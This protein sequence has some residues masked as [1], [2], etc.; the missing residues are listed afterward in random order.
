MPRAKRPDRYAA[1]RAAMLSQ[2]LQARGVTDTA[3]LAALGGLPR[4][5]FV[6]AG[7]EERAYD[8]RALEIGHGQT[9]SQPYM[10]ARMSEELR[11]DAWS[12]AHP[13]SVPK[14]LDVGG[15]SGYQ[16]AV[17]AR[18]GAR[19]ISVE[20]DPDLA[21]AAARRLA[22]LR[23]GSVEMVIGDGSGGWPEAAPYAGI[24]VGA[25]APEVP[26]PLVEQLEDGGR[27]VIPVGSR[28]AQVLLVV[29][30][31]GGGTNERPLE[32]CVFVPLL[33]RY[34]FPVG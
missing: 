4:E 28:F 1:A 31:V 29:E 21:T 26:R 11:L 14:V 27:L 3:V 2:Q 7:L 34:G 24:I 19:V 32:P 6:P 8:D 22:A 20:R 25:A 15:G 17:L 10:V 23:I 13:G 18:M 9:I 16:A 12:A 33:G 5:R 30:R